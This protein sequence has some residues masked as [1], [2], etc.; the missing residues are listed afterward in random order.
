MWGQAEGMS[1]G[2][3]GTGHQWVGCGRPSE[4]GECDRAWGYCAAM[5]GAAS[6]PHRVGCVTGLVPHVG[7]H[8]VAWGHESAGG[9]STR[10]S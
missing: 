9:M 4:W 2:L 7:H 10:F 3:L 8:W 5:G 1:V 6:G